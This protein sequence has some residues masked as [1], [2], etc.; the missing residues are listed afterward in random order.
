MTD[1]ER[2]RTPELLRVRADAERTLAHL[3]PHWT[4]EQAEDLRLAPGQ[5]QRLQELTRRGES[6][7]TAVSHAAAAREKLLRQRE[8]AARDLALLGNGADT[9]MVERALKRAQKSGDG[10]SQLR[11]QRATIDGQREGIVAGI[12]RL[13]RWEGSMEALE[14]LPV[15]EAATIERYRVELDD[16]ARGLAG[17]VQQAV[18]LADEL[19]QAEADLET[20]QR[21]YQAPSL[22]AL[23]T[24][25]RS[26]QEGWN[27]ARAAWEAAIPPDHLEN[28]SAV[29]FVSRMRAHYPAAG[30]LA[31]AFAALVD[32]SDSAA[33]RLRNEAEHVARRAQLESTVAL[34]RE[35]Q[36]ALQLVHKELQDCSEAIAQAW[37]TEWQPAGIAPLSPVEMAEWKAKHDT[38]LQEMGALR[39]NCKAQEALQAT[40]EE[41]QVALLDS[42]RAGGAGEWSDAGSLA[43]LIDRAEAWVE[44]QRASTQQRAHLEKTIAQMDSSGVP[45]AD[46]ALARAREDEAAWRAD[47]SSMMDLLGARAEASPEEALAIVDSIEEILAGHEKA[48]ELQQ[49]IDAILRDDAEFREDLHRIAAEV[50][51]DTTDSVPA[52]VAALYHELQR[53]REAQSTVTRI[54]EQLREE[55]ERQRTAEAA[56]ARAEAELAALCAEAGVDSPAALSEAEKAST[57]RRRL[58]ASR[59][60]IDVRLFALFP[61]QGMEA[62]IAM[63]TAEDAT[64]LAP[65]LEALGEHIE[66]LDDERL[67][68]Q[69]SIGEVKTKL[70][71][72]NGGSQAADAA[73]EAQA[74]IAGIAEDAEEY[75]RIRVAAYTLNRA[76]EHYRAAN[77]EPLLARAGEIFQILTLGSFKELRADVDDRD[78]HVLLGVREQNGAL[79]GVTGMSEGTA[80]QLYLALRIASLERHLERHAPIPF[81]LDDILVNFDDARAAAAL[82]VLAALSDRTQVIYFTHHQHLVELAKAKV[83]EK[84]LFVHG[85][86]G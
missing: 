44:R 83:G 35:K 62:I 78:R 77:Q 26:R 67:A 40:L 30:N 32:D 3:R 38:L 76:I 9:A 68:L 56:L 39:A 43:S 23:E 54:A 29:E 16:A 8:Q 34:L 25:R 37:R 45:E 18:A 85:L 31:D 14:A 75:A 10:E 48:L 60:D 13:G 79:V 19:R 11:Q 63:A 66:D 84:T 41:S 81:I 36:A 82:E 73:E 52:I 2:E 51:H 5:K 4:L 21:Q 47:W 17:N 22:D 6:C 1:L 50:G 42:L 64:A 70:A 20:Y 57:E 55:E 49:R 27:H 69:E 46:A 58:E 80:D 24:L 71:L 61:G 72:M 33:D 74:L 53:S 7:R 59:H 15:P 65:A 12:A 86:N 28:A